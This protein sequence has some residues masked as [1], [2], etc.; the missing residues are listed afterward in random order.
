MMTSSRKKILAIGS[1]WEQFSL[2]KAIKDQGHYL[3]TTHPSFN[4][5]GSALADI[6]YVKNSRDVAAHIKIAET[7]S[8][9]AVVTDNCDFSFFTAT[10]LATKL[11]LPFADIQ[12]AIYSNDKYAQRDQ[13]QK[14]GIKQPMFHRVRTLD[15]VKRAAKS[16]EFPVVLK[17]VDSRG[18]FGVTIAYDNE[19]LEKAYYDA[20]NN[21]SGWNLICEKFIKGTLVTVD[22]FCFKNGHRSLA[23]ASRKYES[24]AKPVTKEIIY[25]AEFSDR[26]N[27]SLFKNHNAVAN[28]LGYKYGHTHGE[29]I[30]SEN[31]DI[32]LVECTNR[33]GGVYTS[34]VIVPY[35][36]GID[37]N[38][39]LINQSLGIDNFEVEDA[40]LRF[41]R[42]SAI[43]AFLDFEVGKV[44]KGINVEEMRQLP[45]VLRYR[46]IYNVNDMVESIENC[47]SRHSMLVIKGSDRE[48]VV[49][50]LRVFKERLKIDYYQS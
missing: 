10:V 20:V 5:E 21:S 8:I 44:I 4:A 33:G 18:T 1:G 38:H 22:G 17:P 42:N 25:P 45:F 2:L 15:D 9:D 23:V 28:A 32:F 39:I 46:T 7:H 27:E 6:S 13:C 30:V 24:G 16:L 29:Y 19:T 34:S 35:L 48:A 50:N 11:K 47:A 37:L 31:G 26:L 40:G 43:L 14:A 36:T 3:I 49:N 12:S 41:L